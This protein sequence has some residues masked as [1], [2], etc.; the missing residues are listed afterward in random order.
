M[1]HPEETWGYICNQRKDAVGAVFSL[2]ILAF[3]ECRLSGFL[4]GAS[5]TVK[6][7]RAP[8]LPGKNATT[9]RT[10]SPLFWRVAKASRDQLGSRTAEGFPEVRGHGVTCAHPE[11]APWPCVILVCLETGVVTQT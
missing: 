6:E 4:A 9:D 8:S 3:L 2:R 10:S 5:D 7:Q 1:I 11:V